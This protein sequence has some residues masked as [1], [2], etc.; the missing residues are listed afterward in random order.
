MT[1]AVANRIGQALIVLLLAFTA[2]FLLLQ[3][4]PGDAILIKYQNPE[5]GLSPEQIAEIRILYGADAPLWAQY[6]N[7]IWNFLQGSFG[8]SVQAGVP[9]NTLL[10]TNLPP[11]LR[12]AALGLLVA[13]VLAFCLA[14][15]ATLAPFRWLRNLLATLPALMISVPVFW[16]GI[17]LIQI[18]SFRLRL[19]PII[20]PNEFQ[21]LI[22]PV[23][24]LA[25]PIAAPLAQ[26]LIRSLDE[27]E[28]QP[29]VSV[30][31]AKGATR[32]GVLWRHVLRNALLP[33]LTIAGL[34]FGELLAGAVVTETV[35]GINGLGRITEQAVS[36]QDT[37]V[38]QAIVIL[39]ALGFVIIN[40]A[41]DLIAPLIDPRLNRKLGADA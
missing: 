15:A 19:V 31:R 39:A 9:V 36:N 6:G 41:V 33:V 34:L 30:A 27:V 1:R 20:N 10:A 11:T 22:L 38:L 8:Y 2:S 25:L 16:L 18:F 32:R 21:A 40:L 7:T 28:A 5:M 3:A 24:T 14:F 26:I 17:M 37:A 29:F 12:L 23:L 35:F 4:L 13:V